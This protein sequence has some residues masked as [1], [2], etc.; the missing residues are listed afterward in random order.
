MAGGYDLDRFV[1]PVDE[2]FRCSICLDVLRNAKLC[3]AGDHHFCFDCI[4]P[5]LANSPTCPVCL[6]LLTPETLQRPQ[7]LLR[8]YLSELIIR[9]VYHNR[10]CREGVQL[11]NLENHENGC[12]YRD[13]TCETCGLQF[14]AREMATHQIYCQLGG[15]EMQQVDDFM[16]NYEEFRTSMDTRVTRIEDM[17]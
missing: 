8:N 12:E 2:D 16:H 4:L 11:G 13:V 6:Q 14:I 3:E 10:G 1:H 7:R 15:A 5:H 17:F 9:C